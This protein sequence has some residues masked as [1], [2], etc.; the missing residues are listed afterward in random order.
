MRAGKSRRRWALA[1]PAFTLAGLTATA[2]TASAAT[3]TAAESASQIV[4]AATAA[5]SGLKAVTIKGSGLDGKQPLSFDIMTST[6]G[7]AQG[8]LSEQGS[9]ISLIEVGST[10]YLRANEKFYTTSGLGKT[11]AA[12]VAGHWLYGSSTTQ[13]FSSFTAFLDLKEF[14]TDLDDGFTGSTFTK[15]GTAKVGGKPVV[16]VTGYDAKAKDGGRLYVAATGTPY[17]LKEVSTGKGN[18]G[19]VTFSGFNQALTTTAPAG[20]VSAATYGL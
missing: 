10:G 14:L 17:I 8:S 16:V 4:P 2:G 6:D 1:V 12:K 7:D 9:T 19:T 11:A 13:P 3:G 18:T 20:A 15:T 5:M